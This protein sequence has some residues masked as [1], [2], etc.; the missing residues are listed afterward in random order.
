MLFLN[1]LKRKNGPKNI[2]HQINVYDTKI[3][4][5][6]VN[7]LP[8]ESVFKKFRAADFLLRFS[9]ILSGS[10]NIHIYIE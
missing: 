7:H 3:E 6:L 5:K 2:L 1:Q 10:E 4:N 9:N 8:L